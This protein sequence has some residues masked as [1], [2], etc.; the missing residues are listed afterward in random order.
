LSDGSL[1]YDENILK[2]C[3]VVIGSIHMWFSQD[4]TQRYLKALDN[5]YLKILGHPTNRIL[6]QRQELKVDWDKVF[7]KALEKGV[8][9]EINCQPL[10]LDLPVPLIKKRKQMWWK[11]SINTDAHS[12]LQLEE[13]SKYWI[14]QAR[15]GW[16]E[17]NDVIN[18]WLNLF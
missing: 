12:V 1:D 8:I 5:P 11:F 13:Y 17:K 4:Q 18:T 14:G 16:V 6:W 2:L 3:D 10:R 15:R 7:K 9:M